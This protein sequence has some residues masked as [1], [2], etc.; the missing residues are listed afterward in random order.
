MKR[1]Y[2]LL[3]LLVFVFIFNGPIKVGAVNQTYTFYNLTNGNM[4]TTSD[5]G[6]NENGRY[7]VQVTQIWG[8]SCSGTNRYAKVRQRSE[9]GAT[10][11]SHYFYFGDLEDYPDDLRVA[12]HANYYGDEDIYFEI[13]VNGM[14]G[15]CHVEIDINPKY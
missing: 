8:S 7:S 10:G 2:V 5:F 12:Y 6:I 13:T 14:S 15:Y 11:G 4:I 1:V 3:L 9:A